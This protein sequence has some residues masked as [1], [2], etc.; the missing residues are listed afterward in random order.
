MGFHK[1]LAAKEHNSIPKVASSNAVVAT[2]M[3]SLS[4]VK[5]LVDI[6]ECNYRKHVYLHK[7][8]AFKH[9]RPCNFLRKK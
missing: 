5:F 9:Q 8:V 6:N 4:F 7:C 1:H 3:L 2:F